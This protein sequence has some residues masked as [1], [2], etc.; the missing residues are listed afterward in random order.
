MQ[1]KAAN[2]EKY[3]DEICSLQQLRLDPDSFP[4]QARH[5]GSTAHINLTRE[6]PIENTPR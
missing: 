3:Y 5:T 6:A 4:S 1:T 2:A